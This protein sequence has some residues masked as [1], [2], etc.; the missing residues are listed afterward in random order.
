[1]KIRKAKKEDISEIA[2]IY[3]EGFSEP[4]FNETWPLNK[5]LK[6][7]KIYSKYCDIWSIIKDGILIG[8]IIINPTLWDMKHFI[9]AEDMGIK[10]E[11]RRKG[12]ATKALKEIFKVYKKK[13]Y[14]KCLAIINKGAKSYGLIKKL[15]LKISKEDLL[16]EKNI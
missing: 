15:N 7:I 2:K 3:A 5:S 14:T 10:K 4:P 6:K 9:F 8:Y 12:L 13:G 16:L 11:L 1:M